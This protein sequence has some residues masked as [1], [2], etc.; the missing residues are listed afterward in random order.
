MATHRTSIHGQWSSKLAFVLAATGSAVGLGNIWKFPYVAGESGG[1]AFV[2]I[3]L[4]CIAVMGIPIMMSEVMLGRRGRQSPINTMHTLSAEEG[5]SRYWGLLGWMGVLAGFLILSYYSVIAG[6]ALAYVLEIAEGSFVGVDP[7]AVD[8]VFSELT[9]DPIKLLFWHSIF[10]M[11]TSFVVAR[12]VAA[13]LESAVRFL[14]PSLFILLL[15]LVA[16]AMTQGH[17]LQGLKF[18][19]QPDFSKLSGQ[20]V[21]AAMGQAFFT[22]SLGMGAIMIYGSYLPQDASIPRTC[23]TV[24]LSDT[25]VAII[26]GLAIFPIVFANALE[27]SQG[28]GLIFKTLPIA[29]GR[30]PGGTFFG[31]LFFV[32]LVFAA[33]TSAISLIEP[34]VAWLVENHGFSRVAATS[35]SGFIT[36]FI[37]LGTVFSFNVWAEYTLFGMTFFDVLD[38]VTANVMLPLGGVLI[39][40]FAAWLMKGS[41][42]RNELGLNHG[43]AY[44]G[45]RFLVRYIAPTGVILVFLHAIGMF[46]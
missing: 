24:A 42:V 34:A 26:A 2:L 32:M 7:E 11:L 19:F 13:G 12:G 22:L 6:W 14:M 38:Y 44:R 18:L 4:I 45:W 15:V 33:W 35:I 46:G 20:A 39:A 23:I 21:L 25:V 8:S 5:R 10:I 43:P 41:S 31:T 27:P 40:I 3:Y 17:F 28:P 29:F 36:W 30:M 1:G 16:Y 9:S 37:G